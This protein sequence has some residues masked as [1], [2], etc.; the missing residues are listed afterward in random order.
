MLFRDLKNWKDANSN[1]GLIFF[2]QRLEELTFPYSLDSYKAPT[3]SLP[4]LIHE[5][6]NAIQISDTFLPEPEVVTKSLEHILEEARLKLKGNFIAKRVSSLELEGLLES[7]HE[8]ESLSNL[9]RRLELAISDLDDQSYFH[10]IVDAVISLASDHRQ[11]SKLDF[12]AR[13]FI[14]FLQH[15]GVSREHVRQS[16]DQVFW[17]ASD[18]DGVEDFRIF[19]RAV[20]PHIHNYIVG[21]GVDS[22]L[23]SFDQS[24]LSHWE[25]T[26]IDADQLLLEESPEGFQVDLIEYS[27]KHAVK[28]IALVATNATDFRSATSAAQRALEDAFNFFRLF[29]HKGEVKLASD[30]VVRQSCCAHD[31]REVNRP[32]NAMHHIRDLRRA[33][34]TSVMKRY[35]ESI[36][37]DV[38]RDSN[39][40]RNIVNIHGMSLSSQSTDIQLV[41]LWTCLETIVPAD[42]SAT[43]VGNV[44]NRL[45][46][47]L[48]LG[49]LNRIVTNLIFDLLRWDRRRF[50]KVIS[51]IGTDDGDDLKQKFVSLLTADHLRDLA[52]DLLSQ[53]GTFE[54]LRYRTFEV[55]TILAD[56][57]SAYKKVLDHERNV[58]WQLHRIYRARNQIVHSGESPE[59]SA[60][61]VENAHDYFDQAMLFCLELSAW[62]P[63]FATFLS[64][65]D[66]AERQFEAY[67]RTL[68]VGSGSDL[69]WRL[70]AMKGRS[71]IFENDD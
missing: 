43:K 28:H 63:L 70:P 44:V 71:A 5:A 54:L 56:G 65:F 68:Q 6:I 34:A 23:A 37:L 16:I 17:S 35:S 15:R 61:L 12:L 53:L 10:T 58:R 52:S 25:I 24:V 30:A 22:V 29:S 42:R 62:K 36:R 27:K 55:A 31:I 7:K 21:I 4:S 40:F 46:P 11:K 57:P 67:K 2:L 47:A 1:R 41:N 26:V 66:Y 49:Y 45:L 51:K 13:E 9:K 48:M 32:S 8:T 19:C 60:L 18:L 33:R 3:M 64:C 20:Y 50:S 69:V 59:Y 38:E 39:K 14:A